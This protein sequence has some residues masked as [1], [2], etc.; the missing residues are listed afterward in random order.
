MI[1]SLTLAERRDANRQFSFSDS[2]YGAGGHEMSEEI[3]VELLEVE[4]V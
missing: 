2:F 3:Q 4:W 1:C